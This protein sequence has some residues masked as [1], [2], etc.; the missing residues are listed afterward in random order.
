MGM[1]ARIF[2]RSYFASIASV[3]VLFIV[4][5]AAPAHAAKMMFGDQE[6]LEKIQDVAIKGQNGEALYLGYKYTH[7]AFVAPYY[8][9]DDGY[10]LGVVDKKSYYKLDAAD[11]TRFQASGLVAEAA[12]VLLAVAARLC[13]R[14]HVVDHPRRYRRRHVVL[15]AQ[16]QEAAGRAAG[17][18]GRP[19]ALEQAGDFKG[20]IAKYDEALGIAPKFADILC[21]RAACH[22]QSGAIDSAI[23]DYSRRSPRSPTMS[24]P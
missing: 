1:I 7:H 11:I 24:A 14:L 22:R 6:Y 20:A 12:A 16:G 5:A 2:P 3:M 18:A 13:F 8:V 19:L 23:A 21:R 15:D 4:A 17:C 9:S 10:I